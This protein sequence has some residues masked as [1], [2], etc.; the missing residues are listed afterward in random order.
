MYSFF[1]KFQFLL[2]SLFEFFG[3]NIYVACN[4]VWSHISQ[5]NVRSNYYLTLPFCSKVVH[6]H[7]NI[8]LKKQKKMRLTT[9]A[10]TMPICL[11][12]CAQ[13]KSSTTNL[14]T[15]S[16]FESLLDTPLYGSYF[17]L[18]FSFLK[19]PKY[20]T[21]FK[22]FPQ[23]SFKQESNFYIN[24]VWRSAKAAIPFLEDIPRDM[25]TT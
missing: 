22:L 18:F 14:N 3:Q 25:T 10:N 20:S 13:M 24:R 8:F 1:K 12:C 5:A 9:L 7:C 2:P 11:C 21:Q 6:Y 17:H 16:D 4:E 19:K 23:G 15:L